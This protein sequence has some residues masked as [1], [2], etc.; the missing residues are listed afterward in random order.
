[1]MSRVLPLL[2]TRCV[3]NALALLRPL[4]MYGYGKDVEILALPA[5]HGV[6]AA[7]WHPKET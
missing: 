1:M 6:A 2:A 3:T 7:S 5:S 4:A